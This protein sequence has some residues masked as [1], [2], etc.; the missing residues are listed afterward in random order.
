MTRSKIE[1]KLF[2]DIREIERMVTRRFR[3]PEMKSVAQWERNALLSCDRNDLIRLGVGKAFSEIE[4]FLEGIIVNYFMDSKKH[5]FKSKKYRLF[6]KTLRQLDFSD[7]EALLREI[8][9]LPPA[10]SRFLA[11]VRSLNKS[12]ARNLSEMEPGKECY[13]RGRSIFDLEAFKRFCRDAEKA[14]GYLTN[15][16]IKTS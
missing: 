5:S 2:E 6:E 14:S 13:Y 8:V 1:K 7:R 3:L 12:T 4:F 16:F 15:Q 10:V 9:S 11:V